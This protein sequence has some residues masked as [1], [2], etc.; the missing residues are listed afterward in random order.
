[1]INITQNVI[2][3]SI[4]HIDIYVI[5]ALTKESIREKFDF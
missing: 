5:P 2:L 4:L 1:M 3:D